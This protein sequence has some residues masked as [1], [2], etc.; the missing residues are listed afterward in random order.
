MRL[1]RLQPPPVTLQP[2]SVA[3]QPPWIDPSVAATA[4]ESRRHRRSPRSQMLPDPPF[5]SHESLSGA[6]RNAPKHNSS[7]VI[8]FRG[9]IR[10]CPY[11]MRL[12][13]H[14]TTV[15][16]TLQNQ[17]GISDSALSWIR[18]WH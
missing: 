3:F 10:I 2:P 1:K 12:L 5:H 13:G 4:V 17:P 11:P 6:Q 8:F 18:A 15:G 16:G 9:H 7:I 14:G